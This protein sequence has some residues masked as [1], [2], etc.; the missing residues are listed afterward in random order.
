MLAVCSYVLEK[1]SANGGRKRSSVGHGGSYGHCPRGSTLSQEQQSPSLGQRGR[2]YS[3]SQ[4]LPGQTQTIHTL[5]AVL[6]SWH[7]IHPIPIISR[8][9]SMKL[10]ANGRFAQSQQMPVLWRWVPGTVLAP[11]WR[12]GTHWGTR[13]TSHP[14]TSKRDNKWQLAQAANQLLQPTFTTISGISQ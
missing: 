8:Y 11:T 2:D 3:S 12:E 13:G 14:W 5:D 4:P 9:L 6:P 1:R 7:L 10:M